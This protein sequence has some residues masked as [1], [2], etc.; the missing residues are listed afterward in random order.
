MAQT[1]ANFTEQQPFLQHFYSLQ[2]N[3]SCINRTQETLKKHSTLEGE[4]AFNLLNLIDKICINLANFSLWCGAS[5]KRPP[6][7]LEKTVA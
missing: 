2:Q 1:L 3:K 5:Y 4:C 7:L 6:F